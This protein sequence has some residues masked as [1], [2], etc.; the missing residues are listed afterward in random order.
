MG[1]SQSSSIRDLVIGLSKEIE[2][3]ETQLAEMQTEIERLRAA[4]EVLANGDHSSQAGN[5]KPSAGGHAKTSTAASALAEHVRSS[6]GDL[7]I[8][9][10]DAGD[11]L[12]KM[13]L[14][15]EKSKRFHVW[16]ALNVGG[17]FERVGHGR[18]RVI[19]VEESPVQP[20]PTSDVN[21]NQE[22]VEND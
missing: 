6:S 10:K 8:T 4:R 21:E 16:Q 15:T 1:S 12:V 3:R 14:T 5:V 11:H 2:L 13:G 18:Y 19:D 20:T 17:Q 9:T 7:T 22:T